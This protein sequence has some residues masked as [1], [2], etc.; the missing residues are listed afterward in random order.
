VPQVAQ[1]QCRRNKSEY[2]QSLAAR[3]DHHAG[4]FTRYPTL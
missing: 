4:H 3:P 2:Y 1:N